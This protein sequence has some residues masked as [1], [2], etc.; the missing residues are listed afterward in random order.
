MN[1]LFKQPQ[2][3]RLLNLSKSVVKSAMLLGLLSMQPY[4]AQAQS[5]QDDACWAIGSIFRPAT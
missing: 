5:G 4:L 2:Q 1:S 3:N